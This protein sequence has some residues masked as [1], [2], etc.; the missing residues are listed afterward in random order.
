MNRKNEEV[1]ICFLVFLFNGI[2]NHEYD[3]YDHND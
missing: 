3:G 2:F 1:L